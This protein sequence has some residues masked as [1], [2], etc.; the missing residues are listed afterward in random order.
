MKGEMIAIIGMLITNAAFLFGCW[1]YF[2][3]RL[4]RVYTRMDEVREGIEEK[5]VRKDNCV[6]LHNNTADN[7]KGLEARIEKRFDKLD[8]Q[9]EQLLK[10]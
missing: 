1:K 7:L 5:Y 9:I 6:L 4:S 8:I 2:D 3:A 10:K